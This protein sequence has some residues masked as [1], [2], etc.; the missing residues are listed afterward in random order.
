MPSIASSKVTMT[1]ILS[2]R[3]AGPGNET[4][5]KRK[6]QTAFY[7]RFQPL[8]PVTNQKPIICV[9]CAWVVPNCIPNNFILTPHSFKYHLTVIRSE[10][11]FK[12]FL[13]SSVQKIIPFTLV[14]CPCTYCRIVNVA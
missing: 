12:L 13:S 6:E 2:Q 10:P 11:K 8:A 1:T 7:D 9:A 3:K 4:L 14:S 5:K